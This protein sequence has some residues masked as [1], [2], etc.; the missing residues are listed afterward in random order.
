MIRTTRRRTTH[1][2][3]AGVAA[4]ALTASACGGDD[5]GGGPFGQQ[6]PDD[7]TIPDL[8]DI[9]IPDLD[10]VTIP[11]DISIPDIPNVGEDCE[12]V[13]A[14][15]GAAA[16]AIGGQ[17]DPEALDEALGRLTDAVPEDLKGDA[18]VFAEAYANFIQAVIDSGSDFGGAFS[19]PDVQQALQAMG[20]PSVAEANENISNWIDESCQAS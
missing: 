9:T 12:A 6:T 10:D 15:L 5:D 19:D 2:A 13:V 14:A 4:L 1:L 16:Q 17:G 18:E 3:L 11:G 8:G 7:I 20:D